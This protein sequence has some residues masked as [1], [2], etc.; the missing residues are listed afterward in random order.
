MEG[1][2]QHPR[3]SSS[4]I[5]TMTCTHPDSQLTVHRERGID[6]GGGDKKEGEESALEWTISEMEIQWECNIK[7]KYV[8]WL[9]KFKGTHA[10][11]VLLQ[12]QTT[13]WS[14][15]TCLD[16]DWLFRFH[17]WAIRLGCGSSPVHAAMITIVT[18]VFLR[19]KEMGLWRQEEGRN[20]LHRV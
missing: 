11:N 6:G 15:H 18:V 13:H 10:R 2:D 16:F 17:A 20:D 8:T 12:E 1:K 3:L 7:A 19:G 14:R 9:T 5:C 4:Y